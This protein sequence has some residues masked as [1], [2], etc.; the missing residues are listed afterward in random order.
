[1]LRL[2]SSD[3]TKPA[4]SHILRP[5]LESFPAA[6]GTLY[7]G[8][9]VF[10]SPDGAKQ[11]DALL[12]SR[13]IGLVAFDLHE[14][15]DLGG[16]VDRQDDLANKI[17]SRLRE[18]RPLM[19][20]RELAIRIRTAT[21]APAC[22]VNDEIQD[23]L[24]RVFRDAPSLV[25]WLKASREGLSAEIFEALVSA[26]QNLGGLRAQQVQRKIVNASSKGAKLR[27]LEDKIATMD[28]SQDQAVLETFEGVQ[29]IRG[30]AGS[31]KT[32]VLAR[33]A[34]LLHSRH[35]DWNIA[36]TFETWSLKA[37][38]ERLIRQFLANQR[39]GEPN[40]EKLHVYSCWGSPSRPGLYSTYCRI[41]NAPYHDV[42][43]AKSRFRASKTLIQGVSA[44]ARKNVADPKPFY[45]A[46]LVDEAQ[47]LPA[48]F[49]QLCYDLLHHPKR[50]VYAYDE[51]QSLDDSSM[52]N[53]EDL[54]GLN[55]DGT[56]KVSLGK[57]QDFILERCYRNSGP[58]LTVAHA[59]GFGVYRKKGLVQIFDDKDLWKDIGYLTLNEGGIKDGLECILSR[60]PDTSPKFLEMDQAPG[61]LVETHVF[62][63]AAHQDEWLIGQIKANRGQD[64]LLPNDILVINPDPF[65]TK[66]NTGSVRAR[67]FAEGIRTIL[68]GVD[69]PADTFFDGESIMFSGIRRARGNEASM[70]YIINAHECYDASSFELARVRNRLFTAITRSKAWVRISGHG[71]AMQQL[72]EE[73]EQVRKENYRLRF[74]YPDEAT[75]AKMKRLNKDRPSAK[76]RLVK[77]IE[78]AIR[79]GQ[80]DFDDIES[81]RHVGFESE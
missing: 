33:K 72:A 76:R 77:Q 4:A 5:I 46:I 43:S 52:P 50:L 73:I 27:G 37:Q 51:L 45:H 34:A 35:P 41:N 71:P 74:P 24:H 53:P 69:A 17:D 16:F 39:L 80:L 67:L 44:E 26:V 36:V 10:G 60:S 25:E 20:G 79:D 32:V 14:E 62:E 22:E 47:D 13:E 31:G 63:D 23:D 64:E 28:A 21:I 30:L 56:P 78:K 6:T 7:L 2:I 75:R 59:L 40:W 81:L 48:E 8:F 12:V 68:A 3:E 70:V 57:N 29:R 42:N 61:I 66:R 49:L 9:P 55:A 65:T 58:V 38:F 1:M 11:I 18:H 19:K 54:F 15:H